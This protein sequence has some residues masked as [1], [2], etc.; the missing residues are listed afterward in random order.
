MMSN[1]GQSRWRSFRDLAADTRNLLS[2]SDEALQY[3][4]HAANRASLA[5]KPYTEA[6]TQKDLHAYRFPQ[7]KIIFPHIP[8]KNTYY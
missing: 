6:P 5:K 7:P 1:P 8:R 2:Q 3:Q 4:L